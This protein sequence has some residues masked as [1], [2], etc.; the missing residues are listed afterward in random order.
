MP[1]IWVLVLLMILL[2]GLTVFSPFTLYQPHHGDGQHLA[3]DWYAHDGK[4]LAPELAVRQIDD[5]RLVDDLPDFIRGQSGPDGA[6]GSVTYVRKLALR[7]QENFVV[8]G[9][10]RSV[11]RYYA[12]Y[13]QAGGND[14]VELL[15]QNGDPSTEQAEQHAFGPPGPLQLDATQPELFLVIQVSNASHFQAGL[16]TAPTLRQGAAA[17]R[18]ENGRL[19]AIMVYAGLFVAIGLYTILLA[20]WH[21][22]ESYYYSGGFVLVLIAIRLVL[23]Q[24]YEWLFVSDVS[25]SLSLRLEYISFFIMLPFFYGLAYGLF[26]DEAS[27]GGMLMLFSV[28]GLFTLA[29]IFAPLD[30]MINTRNVYMLVAGITGIMVLLAFLR[31]RSN[32]RTGANVALVGWAILVIAMIA[33]AL[34]TSTGVLEGMESVPV[35]TVVFAVILMWLF[36]LRY[37][38][39]QAERG[40]LS[41]HLATANAELQARAHDLHQAQKRAADALQIKSSF[42]ANISHEIRTPLN[43][44]I[45]FSD[46]LISQTHSPIDGKKLRDYLQLIRNNGQE[47]LVLMSDIL[48]VSDLEAGRFEVSHD[49]L[50]PEEVVTMAVNLLAP[51]AHE[52]HLFL[53]AQAE[54][55]LI[56]GDIRI[57]RQA[58]IKVLSN[59]V[60][61]AP[62]NGVVTVRGAVHEGAYCVRVTD[63]GAG[64]SREEVDAIMSVFGRAGD[65]YTADGSAVGL[66]VGLPLVSKLLSLVGGKLEVESIPDV[67]TTVS[68]TYPLS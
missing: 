53:D 27:K 7:K 22:G 36:T 20:L 32:G 58:V 59:A 5:A 15:G 46:L 61:Y 10:I 38:Q 60:K 12:V 24:D 28:G 44:I 16:L 30:W 8:P 35:A 17:L 56:E 13:P 48:S 40:A 2:G 11:Y 25:Y 6:F 55:A 34:V 57:L 19:A 68:I 67:G 51:A 52:K 37:R 45:G 66:S 50:D 29:A 9:K 31:A 64:M 3:H 23:L 26:P 49:P 18:T 1:R 14:R 21:A 41:S 33:D 63:T 54:S 39:E 47:L 42:L 62:A 65:A 43:A 4:L